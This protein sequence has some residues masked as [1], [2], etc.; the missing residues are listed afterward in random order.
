LHVYVNV[1]SSSELMFFFSFCMVSVCRSVRLSRCP[2]V[3]AADCPSVSLSQLLSVC[4]LSVSAAVRPSVRPSVSAAAR[5]SVCPSQLPL[6]CTCHVCVECGFII[7]AH[8]LSDRQAACRQ[9]ACRQHRQIHPL[10]SAPRS[11]QATHQMASALHLGRLDL[12]LDL[13]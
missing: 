7:R 4:C 8:L 3:S 5:V 11:G 2:S 6:R 12:D 9:A 10:A 1:G 13:E